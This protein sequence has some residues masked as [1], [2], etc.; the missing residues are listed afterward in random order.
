MPE[1]ELTLGVLSICTVFRLHQ[2]VQRFHIQF[3]GRTDGPFQASSLT[4]KETTNLSQNRTCCHIIKG[5]RATYRVWEAA[6][7]PIRSFIRRRNILP[8]SWRNNPHNWAHGPSSAVSATSARMKEGRG[9]GGE[10]K[11]IL[12]YYL[13]HW[14]FVKIELFFKKHNRS[15]SISLRKGK[16]NLT[17]LSKPYSSFF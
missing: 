14:T 3:D 9:E 17:L 2:A 5:K 12:V 7:L 6:T 11:R 15:Q 13:L 16:K 10:K 4:L 1:G 8:L